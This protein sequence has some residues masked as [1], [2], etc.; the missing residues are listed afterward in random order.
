[1][2]RDIFNGKY[3]ITD[4]MNELGLDDVKEYSFNNIR[5]IGFNLPESIKMMPEGTMR[6]YQEDVIWLMKFFM[7]QERLGGADWIID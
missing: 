2:L 6:Q 3:T 1:M 4:A 5:I 7:L